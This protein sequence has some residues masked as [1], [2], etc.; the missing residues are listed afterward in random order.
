MPSAAKLSPS[1]D[2]DHPL[3]AHS[4]TLLTLTGTT[5]SS[6]QQ[7]ACVSRHLFVDPLSRQRVG[8]APQPQAAKGLLVL[9]MLA[10]D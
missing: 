4:P 3:V 8:T 9:N 10:V 2:P 7:Q 6:L 5:S 1:L